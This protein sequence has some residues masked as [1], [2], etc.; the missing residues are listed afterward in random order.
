MTQR[1]SLWSCF[2][3]FAVGSGLGIAQEAIP[4]QVRLRI[5]SEVVGKEVVEVG[6]RFTSSAALGA[7]Q[8]ELVF[9]P[10]NFRFDEAETG[11]DLK[12]ALLESR[13]KD[14]GRVAVALVSNVGTGSEGELLRLRFSAV[15]SVSTK[16]IFSLENARAWALDTGTELSIVVDPPSNDQSVVEPSQ[17]SS[18][19]TKIEYRLPAWAYAVG[20]AGATAIFF[21]LVMLVRAERKAA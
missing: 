17:V 15:G 9:D 10:K 8:C 4:P 2:L 13:L 21:L 16:R 18:P 19:A 11:V 12:S 6:V 3:Y 14:A 1:F 7:A 20:G 5:E